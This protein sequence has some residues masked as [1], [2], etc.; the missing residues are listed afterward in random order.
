MPKPG[1]S[2]LG[3]SGG[4][5]GWPVT[6]REL[7]VWAFLPRWTQCTAS[8]ALGV[9]G[10]P[11]APALCGSG[12]VTMGRPLVSPVSMSSS[13]SEHGILSTWGV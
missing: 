9:L 8:A 10:P 1:G 7:E 5:R 11:P 13:V 4:L 3:W 6:S 12:P 2:G